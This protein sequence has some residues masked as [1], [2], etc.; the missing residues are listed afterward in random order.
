MALNVNETNRHNLKIVSLN[1]HGFKSSEHVIRSL[2]NNA[3]IIALQETWLYPWDSDV[4]LPSR[5]SHNH[6]AFSTS[7][8]KITERVCA[9]RPHGGL[10]FLWL[11]Q[12]SPLARM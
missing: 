7:S 2:C 11:K 12:I 3:D 5:C 1:C 4:V 6:D 8:I 10:T 9:G